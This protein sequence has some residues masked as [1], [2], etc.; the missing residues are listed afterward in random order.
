MNLLKKKKKMFKNYF[1]IFFVSII[2]S[3]CSGVKETLSLKK[4]TST[5]EFLVKKK[6]PLVMPPEFETLPTPIDN[7]AETTEEEEVLLIDEEIDISKL[8]K[9]NSNKKKQPQNS[10]KSLEK[11]ISDLLKDK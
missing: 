5:N 6:N 7:P 10:S 8:L 2:L 4:K 1:L 3:N 11:S 9:N